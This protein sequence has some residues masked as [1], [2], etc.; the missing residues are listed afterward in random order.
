MA[1]TIPMNVVNRLEKA[2]TYCA[3][4]RYILFRCCK[5]MKEEYQLGDEDDDWITS[6]RTIYKPMDFMDLKWIVDRCNFEHCKDYG[7]PC[8][9]YEQF[10]WECDNDHLVPEQFACDFT[11]QYKTTKNDMAK[12][13][14]N[15]YTE[16]DFLSTSDKLVLNRV[17]RRWKVYGH[18]SVMIDEFYWKLKNKIQKLY[19]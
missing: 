11:I 8:I 12:E 14:K 15:V 19:K 2:R 13:V 18:I 3:L 6:V 17:I 10:S 1:K 9:D 4:L 7:I 5:Q 16:K